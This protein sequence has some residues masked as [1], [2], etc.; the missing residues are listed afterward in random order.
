MVGMLGLFVL[1]LEVLG[2]NRCQFSPGGDTGGIEDVSTLAG[3]YAVHVAPCGALIG[4]LGD[5]VQIASDQ[6]FAELDCAVHVMNPKLVKAYKA[7]LPKTH[8]TDRCLCHRTQSLQRRG[9]GR[10]M[11]GSVSVCA[12]CPQGGGPGFLRLEPDS[13]KVR[14]LLA[15]PQKKG[16]M[17]GIFGVRIE[18][19]IR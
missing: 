12:Q 4:P 18:T 19:V 2:E 7:T 9:R 1:Q 8:K 5:L 15:N 11:R 10:T 16:C 17:T 6:R 13:E 14:K 3:H